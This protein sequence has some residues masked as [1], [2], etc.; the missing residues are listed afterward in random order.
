MNE[1]D[2]LRKLASASRGAPAPRI[3]V[4]DSV[5]RDIAARRDRSGVTLGVFAA[6]AC[7]AAGAA[8]TFA[9]QMLAAGTNPLNDLFSSVTGVL[10]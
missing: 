10:Q 1:I 2:T 8:A 7:A 9:W 5:L 4:A 6:G 3:D